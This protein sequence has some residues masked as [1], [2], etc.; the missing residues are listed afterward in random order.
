LRAFA[1]QTA[2]GM[3]SWQTAEHNGRPYVKVRGSRTGAPDDALAKAT[4]C[5][6]TTPN[7]FVLTL[8]EPLL[9][10]ALDRQAAR[11]NGELATDAP[12]LG[13]NLCF[14]ADQQILHAFQ[15]LMAESFTSKQ[16]RLSW[17][18]LPILNEWK[19]L[20]PDRDPVKLHEQL[21]H[22]RLLCPEGGSYVW[23]EKWQTMESTVFGHPAEPK[24]GSERGGLL[25]RL[26]SV[27]LGLTFEHQGLSAKAVLQRELKST[28]LN[29]KKVA[30]A[31]P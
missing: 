13:T 9:K 18:N 5:Y 6:A 15:A 21:W 30:S 20:Y 8:D 11:P 26:Q 22:A 3:A 27:D 31:A 24:K 16:Q 19:R 29:D 1:E 7:S 28:A 14:K 12:W 10:R 17:D 25:A 23:N 2:P 4:I